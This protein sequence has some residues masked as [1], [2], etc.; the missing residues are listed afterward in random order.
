MAESFAEFTAKPYKKHACGQAGRKAKRTLVQAFT[1]TEPKNKEKEAAQFEFL[2]DNVMQTK[3][4]KETLTTLSKLGYSFAFEKGNFG[5]YCNPDS[6]QIVINPTF[7]E[8]YQMQTLVHEGRHAIQ[9]SLKLPETANDY[10]VMMVASHLKSRRAIEA[11]AVAHEMAFVYE[12]KK[13]LPEVYEDAKKAGL[14]MFKA[15][16]AEMEHS[17]DGRKAMQA[18]FNAWYECEFYR[19]F[20][21]KWHKN[22]IKEICSCGKNCKDASFFSKEVSSEDILSICAYKGKPYMS[23]KEI[24]TGLPSAIKE[25]D[26]KE[27]FAMVK[28]YATAVSV[29]PDESVLSMPSRDKILAQKEATRASE[30]LVMK[31]SLMQKAQSR[32]GR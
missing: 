30:K 2:I 17:H 22:A 12:T 6:K 1:P 3:K 28:D 21:D 31:K 9:N 32:S 27:I 14:P 18:S 8:S 24:D 4:G 26:K 13:V 7:S 11:D 20:Y 16:E 25:S 5:G 19:D 23:V 29:K 10:E 15:Y